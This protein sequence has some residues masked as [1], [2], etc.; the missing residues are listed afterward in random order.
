MKKL[1]L[2]SVLLIVVGFYSCA[3]YS[4]AT[5]RNWKEFQMPPSQIIRNGDVFFEGRL[6]VGS[7]FNVFSD[8][9][10]DIDAKYYYTMLMQDFGWSKKS[11]ETWTAPYNA[12]D[13][14]LGHLYV[15]PKK[16][17]AIYFYPDRNYSAFK[18]NITR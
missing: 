5:A 17:V 2:F 10:V 8:E 18:V 3:T 4:S 11:D 9:K 1:Y 14:K 13:K 16:G 15:N 12:R 6:T 7:G